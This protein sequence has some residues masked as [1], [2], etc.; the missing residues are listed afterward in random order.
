MNK[1]LDIIGIGECM[2]E[3]FAEEPLGQA[4]SLQRSFGGDVLNALVTAARLGSRVGFVTQVGRDPFGP[5]LLEAWLAEGIDTRCAPLVPGENG[6]YFISLRDGGEREFTYRRKDSAASRLS[7]EN[8]DL[9][10]LQQSRMLLLSGISQAVSESAQDAALRAA[11]LVGSGGALVAFDPN[12]RPNLWALRGPSEAARQALEQIEPHLDI[13]LPSFP[14]DMAVFGVEGLD[15]KSAAVA[16]AERVPRVALK[17]GAAGAWLAWDGEL[18]HIAPA[19]T[20]RV[21]DTTGA[22]DAW[23][24][25]FLHGLLHSQEPFEAARRANQIAADKLAFRGAIAPKPWPLRATF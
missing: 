17:A 3:F 5:G 19:V 24:G 22:G 4:R 8:L 23:N 25:A 2:V 10:Y 1:T 15:V 16:L 14:D 11:R 18:E 20:A 13:L 21:R 9:W 7:A 12:H 6:V